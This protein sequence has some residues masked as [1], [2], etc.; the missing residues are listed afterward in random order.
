M[1]TLLS[2]IF[3]LLIFSQNSLFAATQQSEQGNNISINSDY[4][5]HKIK[6]GESLETIA[7]RYK[8]S[9]KDI[10]KWN[11]LKSNKIVSGKTLKIMT[12]KKFTDDKII[13]FK[14][15][16]NKE[17]SYKIQKGDNLSSI[18]N[19]YGVTV[20]QI[21]EWN[22]LSSDK[23][24]SGEILKI[25]SGEKN[26]K[27]NVKNDKEENF[28]IVK[29]G[30]TIDVI[31]NKYNVSVQDV[32]V[33]NN[34]KNYKLKFGQKLLLIESDKLIV[35]ENKKEKKYSDIKIHYVKKGE[36]LLD[37]AQKYNVSVDKLKKYN[38]LKDIKSI[39]GRSW[40][41]IQMSIK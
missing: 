41:S 30:E 12:N 37:I 24:I 17:L 40:K 11:N 22:N 34:L 9:I 28:H 10:K 18:A 23:I 35:N 16:K 26:K 36:T 14:N 13:S 15:K 8:V 38:R 20:K 19:K 29:K 1:K 7:T 21:K 6:K 32:M 25:F 31:A 5:K 39:Q 2:F 4:I 33:W 3:I 27:Y